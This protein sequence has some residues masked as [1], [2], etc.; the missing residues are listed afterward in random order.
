MGKDAKKSVQNGNKTNKETDERREFQKRIRAERNELDRVAACIMVRGH[1]PVTILRT[2]ATAKERRESITH[3]KIFQD[4]PKEGK[5]SRDGY[6]LSSIEVYDET[7]RNYAYWAVS[8]PMAFGGMHQMTEVLLGNKLDTPLERADECIGA[9]EALHEWGQQWVNATGNFL[10]TVKEAGGAST[11]ARMQGLTYEEKG[12]ATK[13]QGGKKKPEIEEESGY[14]SD[15]P[16]KMPDKGRGAGSSHPSKNATHPA[17][18]AKGPSPPSATKE[19][20]VQQGM[21]AWE[22][23]QGTH[24]S[25]SAASYSLSANVTAGADDQHRSDVSD[26]E[27]DVD[28]P[29]RTTRQ[30][31]NARK[32]DIVGKKDEAAKNAKNPGSTSSSKKDE[33]AK[34]AKNPGSSGSS[35]KDEAAKKAKNS[36]R[37]GSSKKDEEDRGDAGDHEG[38]EDVSIRVTRQRMNPGKPGSGGSSNKGQEA[39]K[40]KN[41]GSGGSSKEVENSHSGGS[42][43]NKRKSVTWAEKDSDKAEGSHHDEVTKKPR[44]EDVNLMDYGDCAVLKPGE[45]DVYHDTKEGGGAKDDGSG[46]EED[47]NNNGSG[48]E[49][50]EDEDVVE[51]DEEG[52]GEDDEAEDSCN[53]DGSGG[54]EEDDGDSDRAS[55]C[56]LDDL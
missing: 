33:A 46:E 37:G 30:K 10:R 56:C 18:K 40:T 9:I 6:R 21:K 22:D 4:I 39:M 1:Q 12:G 7:Q 34:N 32:S 31:M 38:E 2:P 28:Y 41:P 13:Q 20:L 26:S 5:G 49:D 45:S 44:N 35:K 16:L 36:E 50:D 53:E 52:S 3:D 51:D 43:G 17:T 48:E 14:D 15:R 47:N 8:L 54:D 24:G 23:L 11:I 42:V 25:L 27:G 19:A 29:P 55:V